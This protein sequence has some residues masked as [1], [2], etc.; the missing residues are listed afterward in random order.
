M[1]DHEPLRVYWQPG[2]SSCLQAKEF[3]TKHGVGFESINVLAEPAARVALAELG[4]RAVP[5]VAR[6]TDFVAGQNLDELAAFVGVARP[7]VA[8]SAD[9][10]ANRIAA[11]LDHAQQQ[12][13]AMPKDAS[14]IELRPGRTLADLGYHVFAIVEGFLS[15]ANG[16]ELT[17]SYFTRLP[18]RSWS[19]TRIAAAG[20]AVQSDFADW[21]RSDSIQSQT[22]E[23]YYGPQSVGELLERTAWHVAQHLRQ[24]AAV[25][26]R[27][28]TASPCEVPQRL[29]SGLP[30]PERV[31]DDEQR[32]ELERVAR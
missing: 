12:L 16:G 31:W 21:L 25:L 7:P 19:L 26:Q 28:S 20:A 2:C 24:I 13:A 9:A 15:A 29:L 8:L 22:L 1:G 32:L 14:E 30:L 6:G 18:D 17:E 23:T 3:L 27:L 4:A 10:L 11:L 5:V